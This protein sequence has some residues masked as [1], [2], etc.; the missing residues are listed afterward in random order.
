VQGKGD[1]KT[2]K[3]KGPDKGKGKGSKGLSKKAE[4]NLDYR[5]SR[6][7]AAVLRHGRGKKGCAVVASM[8]SQ[9]EVE[10]ELL[11]KTMGLASSRLRYLAQTSVHPSGDRRYELLEWAGSEYLRA[12][13]EHSLAVAG[14]DSDLRGPP[15]S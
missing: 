15:D 1:G 6:A 11:A 2:R 4:K 3:G 5:D 9:G 14:G 7:L 10:L 8:G 12:T 13:N